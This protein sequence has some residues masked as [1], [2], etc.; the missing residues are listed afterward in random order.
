MSELDG[1]W[2]VEPLPGVTKRIDGDRGET[3]FGPLPG[4][5]FKVRGLELDYGLGLV[6]RLE[7]DGDGYRLT[8]TFRGRRLARFRLRRL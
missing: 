2:K 7:P 8:A 5:P 6:D 3:R 1:L 4:V